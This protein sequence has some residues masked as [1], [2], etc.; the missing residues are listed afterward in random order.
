M[1]SLS[2]CQKSSGRKF[3][4]YD[5]S[6]N[7]F[8]FAYRTVMCP[9]LTDLVMHLG[10]ALHMCFDDAAY[11]AAVHAMPVQSL[12]GRVKLPGYI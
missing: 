10:F 4:A 2:F 11:A 12:T 9:Q 7:P 6:A 8:A 3:N 1:K 5:A